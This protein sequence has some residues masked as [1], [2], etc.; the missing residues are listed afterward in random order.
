MIPFSFTMYVTT[1]TTD[2]KTY[3]GGQQVVVSVEMQTDLLDF[4]GY[5]LQI[6]R[7]MKVPGIDDGWEVWG[8]DTGEGLKGFSAVS[9]GIFGPPRATIK[10]IAPQNT[11]TW[12]VLVVD[13]NN[14]KTA[15]GRF[16]DV[17]A[18]NPGAI[19]QFDILP[20]ASSGK[21][22]F[23][24]T[25]VPNAA[26]VYTND[27]YVGDTTNVGFPVEVVPGVY[28]IRF[29]PPESLATKFSYTT[30]HVGITAGERKAVQASLPLISPAQQAA[31][32]AAAQQQQQQQ[33]FDLNA[34][35]GSF[36]GG[37]GK[38]VSDNALW[39]GIGAA[40]LITLY[41][42]SKPSGR[43]RAK[44]Y[45]SAGGKMAYEGAVGASEVAR[46]AIE[47]YKAASAD[48]K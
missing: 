4:G 30:Q 21:G 32:A 42:L 33:G 13:V 17:I 5:E 48:K 23:V 35:I 41:I 19:K 43:S 10:R 11:G 39:I 26:H 25:S 2:Q 45:A 34:F 3:Y 37:A 40:G 9:G 47:G 14:L 46:A 7:R 29:D 20:S 18:K 8:G 24:F 44:R 12:E 6:Y 27:V 22:V 1:V 15:Q 36:T 31:A 28:T 38:F 16:S